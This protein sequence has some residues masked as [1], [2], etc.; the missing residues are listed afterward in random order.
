MKLKTRFLISIF[1]VLVGFASVSGLTTYLVVSI[2]SFSKAVV[3]CNNTINTLKHLQLLTVELLTT[4]ELDKTFDKW[5]ETHHKF[6]VELNTLNRSPEIQHLL[7]TKEQKSVL[8]SM[9]KFWEFTSVKTALIDKGISN[10]LARKNQ[11]RDG[12][13]HQYA[14]SKDYDVLVVRNDI[15]YALLFL[16]AE[17]EIRLARLITFVEQEK[18]YQFKRLIVM[19]ALIGLIIFSVVS[20]LLISFLNRLKDYLEKLHNSMTLIGK[21][22]FSEKMEIQGN[23]ELGQIAIAINKTTDSLSQ[24]HTDLEQR[25]QSRTDELAKQTEAL[26]QAKEAAEVANQAKSE[27]L[28]NISHEIRTP[29]HQI[30]SYSTFGVNKIEKVNKEKL[31]HYFSK[32]GIIGRNLLALMNDLLDLSKLESGKM[33]YD[34]QKQD[35]MQIINSVSNEFTSLVLGKNLHLKIENNSTTRV[36]ECDEYKIGQVIRNF[37]SNAVK[38]SPKG[39]HITLSIEISHLTIGN[40]PSNQRTI[41]AVL[42]S[43]SDQGVGLPENELNSVFDKFVQSSKTKTNAGGTGL[44]LAI[45][46]EIILGH[47][48]KIW[49]ENN[50]DGGATFNFLVPQ[51]QD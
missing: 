14:E 18:A 28:S 4:L 45:C 33:N 27:F 15:S 26:I 51:E 34:M 37:L 21:G 7:V 1:A 16:E 13:L 10:I 22:D 9:N 49:A 31:L 42:V 35:L 30:L 3:I 19:V 29:M 6:K 43:V 50:A 38:F 11:N 17:F 39:S 8:Q 44:G 12:L 40:Q 5:Q 48:G 20:F 25:V 2:N 46:K 32:I 41:S 24:M 23:D 47:S 36:I